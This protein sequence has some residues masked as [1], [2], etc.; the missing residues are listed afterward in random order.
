MV[1]LDKDSNLQLGIYMKKKILT[2]TTDF[3]H[4]FKIPFFSYLI[5]FP[6]KFFCISPPWLL[7]KHIVS[8]VPTTNIRYYVLIHSQ[9]LFYY[10]SG[11]PHSLRHAIENKRD[12]FPNEF[13]LKIV[14]IMY[15]LE[16]PSYY[17]YGKCLNDVFDV[18]KK[19]LNSC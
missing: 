13:S 18:P 17:S 3:F 19:Y 4:K 5:F 6:N 15:S 1:Y 12:I 8:T 11:A 14:V 2:L 7:E 10:F 9:I 16:I